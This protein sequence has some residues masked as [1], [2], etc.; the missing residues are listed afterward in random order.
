MSCSQNKNPLASQGLVKLKI[1]TLKKCNQ[2]VISLFLL[3]F[4]FLLFSFLA[5]TRKLR[6]IS[7]FSQ[8]RPS[9]LVHTM[10]NTQTHTNMDS[11]HVYTIIYIL[12][13][14]VSTDFSVPLA[15][16]IQR[17]LIR[18]RLLAGP[19]EESVLFVHLFTWN[20]SWTFPWIRPSAIFWGIRKEQNT[21]LPLVRA[22]FSWGRLMTG[23]YT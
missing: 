1:K 22:P 5:V 3:Y 8:G 6:E 14:R 4:I 2:A 7:Y 19:M 12:Y 15:I 20:I 18:E 9:N 16:F 23:K 17:M 11:K 13:T 10:R 21:I